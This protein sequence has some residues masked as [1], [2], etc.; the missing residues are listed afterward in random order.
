MQQQRR[1]AAIQ[2]YYEDWMMRE[3]IPIHE[4]VAG[5]DDV[6]ELPRKP[7]PRTGG[8]GSFIHMLGPKQAERGIYVGEIP[9]GEIPEPG[10][11]PISRGN[12]H[13]QGSRQH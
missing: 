9:G 13:P 4:A 5:L 12:Y 11:T 2:N 8:L 3:G 6:T 10:K 1:D 7:W